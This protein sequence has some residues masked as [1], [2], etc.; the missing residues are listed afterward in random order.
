M[1]RAKVALLLVGVAMVLGACLKTD[2]FPEEP[3][4]GFKEFKTFGDSA[5][6]TITFTDGDGD[7][8]LGQGDTLPPFDTMPFVFNL[9]VEYEELQNG[10]WVPFTGFTFPFLHQRVP[11]ITPTGQNKTLEGEITYRFTDWPTIP[12]TPWDTVRYTVKLVDRALHESNTVRTDEI[13]LP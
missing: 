4:I 3:I 10:V 1:L 5:A 2:E 7:I 12:N 13:I 11:L 6:L 8:G 9:F